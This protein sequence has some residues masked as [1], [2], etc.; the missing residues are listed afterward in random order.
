MIAFLKDFYETSKNFPDRPAIVDRDGT[1]VTTYRELFAAA[2]KVNA[3]LRKHN[4]G[5]EDVIAIYFPKS[6]EYIATRIGIMMSGGAWV[7]LD[8]IMGKERINFVIR[9]S[10]CKVIFNKEKWAEAM[11][12]PPCNEIADSDIHDLAFM[13]YT[14]GSTG[15]PKGAAQEYGVYESISK[16]GNKVV[17]A[18]AAPEPMNAADVAPQIFLSG[19]F[20][21]V[22][23]L[24]IRGTIHEIST[25]MLRNAEALGDYFIEKNIHHAFL[26]VSLIRFILQ[27]PRIRLRAACTG[28]EIVSDVYTDR[29]DIINVYGASEFGFPVC[30]F[31]LDHAYQNTPIGYPSCQSD[32]VLLD[33]SGHPSDEGAFCI[34]LPFFRGYVGQDRDGFITINGKEYFK[35]SEAVFT[36]VSVKCEDERFGS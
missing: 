10:G 14:S 32:I 23:I 22:C 35:T 18:Y 6:M 5:R 26:P 15:A 36:T 17:E 31:T 28:G 4:L 24:N 34:R 25:D 13:I 30:L 27:N 11:L 20:F 8:D 12:L 3:W 19:V 9:D 21:T 1:R 29:F 7:G 2:L 16:G 33:E